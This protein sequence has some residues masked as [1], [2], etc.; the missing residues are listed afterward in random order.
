MGKLKPFS[1][2]LAFATAVLCAAI[3]GGLVHSAS[4]TDEYY[5]NGCFLGAVPAVSGVAYHT[6]NAMQFEDGYSGPNWLEIYLYN[7]STN[8]TT[9]G[10]SQWT[11]Y[12][13]RSCANSGTARCHY[14]NGASGTTYCDAVS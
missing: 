6:F 5:C 10:S 13:F 2:K 11:A 8:T 14:Y 4:A 12:N 3:A 9:C 7:A 1:L